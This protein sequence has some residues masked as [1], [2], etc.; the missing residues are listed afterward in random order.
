ML[1]NVPL[2]DNIR[3]YNVALGDMTGEAEMFVETENNGV[4]CSLLEPKLHLIQYPKIKFHSI[5]IVK[6][7]KLDNIEFDRNNFNMI[8]IDVQG[9]ELEVFKGGKDTLN[10]IDII[11]TEVNRDEVAYTPCYV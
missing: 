2:T 4:S 1:L 6:V 5:E 3:A 11:Y 7:D 8:N 10:N 9:Y